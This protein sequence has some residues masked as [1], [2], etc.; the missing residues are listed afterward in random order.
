MSEEK[1]KFE[2]P[3]E[4]NRALEDMMAE[5]KKKLESVWGKLHPG[6]KPNVPL[7]PGP[8]DDNRPDED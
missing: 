8:T 4:A 2:D 6:G 7:Q 1:P 5:Q 3:E